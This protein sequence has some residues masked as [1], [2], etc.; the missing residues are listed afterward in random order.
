M[1]TKSQDIGGDK[2]YLS[3]EGFT[4][5]KEKLHTLKASRRLEIAQHLEFAKSLGDLSENA[6]YAEAKEEQMINESEILKLEDLLARAEIISH[7]ATPE[8]RIGSTVFF[9]NQGKRQQFTIVGKEE[10]DPSKGKISHESPLGRAFLGRKKNEK[11]FVST[12][13]GQ[14]EYRITDVS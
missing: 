6:E 2:A 11:I 4:E 10:A 13:K 7:V 12:P 5:L 14:Q 8:V 9:E 1:N 3:R